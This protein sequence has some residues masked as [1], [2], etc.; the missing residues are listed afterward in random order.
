MSRL[1]PMVVAILFC[2]LLVGDVSSF[3]VVPLASVTPRKCYSD[4]TSVAAAHPNLLDARPRSVLRMSTADVV[5]TSSASVDDAPRATELYACPQ[6]GDSIAL[7]DT[8]CSS[9]GAP[10]ATADGFTD[11][12]PEATAPPVREAE[13]TDAERVARELRKNP[14]VSAG[15]AAVASST[16][17]QVT[18]QPFRQE[19]FRTPLLSFLYERGWRDGFKQAG[20][21]GIEKEF[22]MVMDFFAEA[23]E[24]NGTVIDLSC[25]SGLMVRR[26]AKSEAFGKVVAVDFSENMLKEVLRRSAEEKVPAFDLVRADVARMPFATDAVDAI[27]SGAALHCWPFVQDGLREVHRVLRPGGAFF[28]T[29][30]LW[31]IDDRVVN[32]QQNLGS[33]VRSPTTIAAHAWRTPH[34]RPSARILHSWWRR[35][36]R[37]RDADTR[38][39]FR[40]QRCGA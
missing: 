2:A 4:R 37:A 36:G 31:G 6:C 14:L 27:H 10:V 35:W 20:F 28:A 29:T 8:A 23:R 15:L 1:W 5:D 30:F 33:Q 32:L 13:A 38:A 7:Q 3:S 16:G 22:E 19:L 39:A 26:I 21:P 17:L 40:K 11:L 24:A 9:C 12:T 34:V 18:G 25:G